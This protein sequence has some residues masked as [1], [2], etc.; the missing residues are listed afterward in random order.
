Q[1]NLHL[2]SQSYAADDGETHSASFHRNAYSVPA[3]R[4]W[5]F[6][7]CRQT[8]NAD[9]IT[10]CSSTSCPGCEINQTPRGKAP[11]AIIEPAEIYPVPA[12]TTMKTSS[13]PNNGMG[14]MSTNP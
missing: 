2:H 6:D 12:T 3:R 7:L 4:R 14:P 13:D 8:M 1:T 5:R 9:A 11:T 10:E